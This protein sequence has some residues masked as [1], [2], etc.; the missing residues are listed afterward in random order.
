VSSKGSVVVLERDPLIQKLLERWLL[1]AGYLV[2]SPED[3]PDVPPV[4]IIADVPEPLLAGSLIREWKRMYA[5]P[6]V[7]LS[8]RFRRGLAGSA[9]T[10][11][12]LGV[13]K[14]LPKP[15]TRRELLSAVRESV[16][17]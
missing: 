6:I 12:Q 11:R 10:A 1:E 7:I 2:L 3:K 17:T 13:A 5:A 14:V 16:S 15:F 8:A 4:L 9:K